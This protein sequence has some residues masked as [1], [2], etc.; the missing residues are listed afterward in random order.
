MGFKED[1][2]DDLNCVFYSEESEFAELIDFDGT[3]ISGIFSKITKDSAFF[4]DSIEDEI[5]VSKDSKML[6]VKKSD[7]QIVPE[8]GVEV[9]INGKDYK[10][11]KIIENMG[12]FDMYIARMEE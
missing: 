10:I 11:V 3:Q 2:E 4:S 1:L 12:K 8:E 9:T 5:N 7:L 6:S